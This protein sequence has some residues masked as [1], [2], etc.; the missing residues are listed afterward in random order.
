MDAAG[1]PALALEPRK[2]EKRGAARPS[3]AGK[4]PFGRGGQVWRDGDWLGPCGAH[5]FKRNTTCKGCGAPRP[6]DDAASDAAYRNALEA[7]Y[8]VPTRGAHG[9]HS[10]LPP[11]V[12]GHADW[13]A[14]VGSARRGDVVARAVRQYA[15]ETETMQQERQLASARAALEAPSELSSSP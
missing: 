4:N 3:R 8:V 14:A 15:Q 2:R 7:E 5:N 11:V 10:A 13:T 6:E 9:D 12:P 1:G